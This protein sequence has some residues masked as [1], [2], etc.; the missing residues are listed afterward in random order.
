MKSVASISYPDRPSERDRWIVERRGSRQVVDSQRPY[1]FFAEEERLGDGTVGTTATIFLTNRECPWRC[2][3]CDLWK[4]TV[5][6]SVMPG[7]I[8]RQI[9][10]ALARMPNARQVKLY[11]SGSFFDPQA[12]PITDYEGIASLLTGFDR[13]VVECHPALI[14]ENCFAFGRRLAGRLEVAMG[15]E[16][17]HPVVLEKLN[18]RMT[19]EDYSRAAKALRQ[20]DI[21]LRCF[22]L[23][24]PP[25]MLE[26]E[27]LAW[28]CRSIDFARECRATAMTLIPTRG[29]N[30]AM[31]V[32]AELQLFQSP[33][34]SVVED[35]FEYGLR[36][37]GSRV[38][39]DLWDQAGIRSSCICRQDRLAR[40]ATMNLSQVAFRRKRCSACGEGE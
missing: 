29:G 8:T 39:I 21:Y 28:A 30:G 16:T 26:E 25:F 7:E 17:A 13:V 20:H 6:K 1:A 19:L 37:G 38:F 12:I 9:E 18:K 23:I 11:N 22:I 4:H 27:A 36:L 14:G 33:K 40:M 35:A 24:Q 10:Y 15:L 34:L 32:L 5:T 2:A 3:M 31:D